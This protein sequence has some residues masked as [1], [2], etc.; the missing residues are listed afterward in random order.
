MRDERIRD[1]LFEK[2]HHRGK[3]GAGAIGEIRIASDGTVVTM[4]ADMKI[5]VSD[6]R[7]SFESVVAIGTHKDFIYSMEVKGK[8]VIS[9]SGDGELLVHD[10]T[11]GRCLYGL[12]GHRN[13][14]R[15]LGVTDQRLVAVGDDGDVRFYSMV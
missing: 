2:Y 3:D 1:C 9:G 5:C 8:A 11:T 6:P 15:S 7:A 10:L 4:G 13:A 14:V 12:E